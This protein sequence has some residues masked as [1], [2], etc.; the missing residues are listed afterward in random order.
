M[1]MDAAVPLAEAPAPARRDVRSFLNHQLR[2]VLENA[3]IR[4]GVVGFLLV[5][6]SA[7]NLVP[8]PTGMES[9]WMFIVPVAISSIAGGLREGLLI[10]LAASAL[11]SLFSYPGSLDVDALAVFGGV[12]ARFALYGITAV[13]LGAFADAHYAVQ[14]SLRELASTDPL[15]KVANVTSFY[16]QL[17]VLEAGMSSF[18]VLLCDLDDLKAI[19]DRFGHQ[20]G[21]EAIQATADVLRDVVRGTDCVARYGGDEF[22]VTLKDADRAG[23]ERVVMR[24]REMLRRVELVHAPGHGV[25]VSIGVS[26]F[27]ED[28]TT[29]EDLVRAA[30]TAMYAN[31]RFHKGMRRATQLTS[32]E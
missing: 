28:G 1:E 20:A 5:A 14:S 26:V 9:S 22:V 19:N 8:Q 4:Y 16:E 27:G 32:A 25:T 21:S 23:A 31:K 17:G 11:S 3:S 29:A 2:P 15:T 6:A 7:F 24:A 10:A 12:P 18:A 13:F 30:D